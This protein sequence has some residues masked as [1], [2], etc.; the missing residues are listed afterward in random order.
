M[1][2]VTMHTGTGADGFTILPNSNY[3]INQGDADNLYDQYNPTTGARIAGTNFSVAG[4]RTVTGRD[5]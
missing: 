3:L 5:R 2:P 4:Y 1:P